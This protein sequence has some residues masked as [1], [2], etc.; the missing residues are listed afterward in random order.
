METKHPYSKSLK[1]NK[2]VIGEILEFMSRE[3]VF[4][5][6]LLSKSFRDASQ[7]S[8]IKKGYTCS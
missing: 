2:N 4:K 3:E 6:R 7:Y 5:S 1:L 8:Q